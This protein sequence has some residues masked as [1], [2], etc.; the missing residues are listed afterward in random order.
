MLT[1]LIAKDDVPIEAIARLLK[2]Q[3]APE[4]FTLKMNDIL[5]EGKTLEAADLV[6]LFS[7]KP[8]L[9]NVG[10]NVA[11]IRQRLTQQQRLVLCMPRPGNLP[12]LLEMGVADIISPAGSTNESVAERV[13]GH[14]IL[15]EHKR[16]PKDYY[17]MYGATQQ[18]CELY[19][20]IDKYAPLV[21]ESVLIRGE[22]GT[23]KELVAKSLHERAKRTG[24]LMRIDCSTI[25]G[26]IAESEFFGHVQGAFTGAEAKRVGLFEA[27][28]KG[29]AFL[30]E[31]GDLEKPLQ[32]KLLHA[33][34]YQQVRPM[35]AN[36]YKD[37]DTRFVF[38]TRRDLEKL[39]AEEKFRKDLYAR[40][41][42]LVLKLPPLRERMADIPLLVEH[43]VNSFN[44]DNEPSVQVQAGPGA[45]NEL[46]HY[47]WPSNV[48]ELKQVV[49][50]AA[51]KAGADGLITDVM[52]N[53][54]IPKSEE[55]WMAQ[56]RSAQ[57]RNVLEIDPRRYSWSGIQNNLKSA[58]FRLLVEVAE[59]R[60]EALKLSGLKPARLHEIL[61]E[62]NLKLRSRN[63]KTD[64]N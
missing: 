17:G 49:K 4:V 30:D 12:A 14:L 6:I 7:V 34:E 27:A 62:L 25:S 26:N 37:V 41:N 50:K 51:A 32:A 3:G 39:V 24:K 44:L 45:V 63:D 64:T 47:D 33:V 61:T 23:G 48:R 53:Q 15:E 57:T 10:D 35:G 60:K 38:A 56:A 22:T 36:E 31:I 29:T 8:E 40:I 52:F 16:H 5:Y 54:S 20:T 58:Y 42:G 13:M 18:M 9:L 43:F 1:A 11:Q 59:N 55:F 21:G 46:F 2:Q 28:K 19:E